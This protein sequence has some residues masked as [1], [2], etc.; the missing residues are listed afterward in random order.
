KIGKIAEE[1]Q[2]PY[3]VNAAYTGGILPVSLRKIKADFLTISAHKSMA[4]LGPLGFLVTRYDWEKKIFQTSKIITDWSGRVFG[5]KVVNLFGCS[6]GGIPLISAMYSFP[7]VKERVKNWSK[8]LEK[9]TWLIKQLEKLDDI[10]LIGQ[11]P[12]KHHLTSFETPI[13]WLISQKHKRKGFFLAEDMI[14]RGITGLHKGLSKHIKLSVYGL[15]WDEVKKVKESFYTIAE[16]YS[17][18]YDIPLAKH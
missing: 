3:M 11:N 16:T 9:T 8:E 4:S 12:H 17:K 13:F 6:I 10:M 14:K 5:E 18:K 2:I 15:T 7:Y 1:Y